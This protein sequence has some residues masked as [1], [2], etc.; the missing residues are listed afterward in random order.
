LSSFHHDTQGSGVLFPVVSLAAYPNAV[1][2]S[3]H[4]RSWGR[5]STEGGHQ[6]DDQEYDPEESEAPYRLDPKTVLWF[7]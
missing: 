6:A 5:S 3:R 7:F 2:S 1:A 4:E